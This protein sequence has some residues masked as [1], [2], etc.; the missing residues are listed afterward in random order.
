MTKAILFA[1]AVL[2]SGCAAVSTTGTAALPDGNVSYA[3]VGPASPG[4]PTV[5]FQ[6]GLGDGKVVWSQVLPAVQQHAQVFAYDRPGYGASRMIPGPRD[7]CT[8]AAEERRVLQV[9]GVK[10]PY[11]LVGHS[12]GG[13]YQY[14][15]AKMYPADVAGIV[16][17][18]PTHPRH[19]ETLQRDMPTTASA[20]KTMGSVMF[21]A[22]MRREFD[23]QT[24]CLNTINMAAPLHVPARVLISTETSML[25][26]ASFKESVDGLSADWARMT[27]AARAEPIAKSGHYIQREQPQAVIDA[28]TAVLR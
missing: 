18:D 26:S 12:L 5:V 17:L 13:L 23:D 16:L 7:A 19:W 2:L 25:M 21:Q 9:A 11:L 22:A 1:A 14:V 6:S 27:G 4:N 20:I 24:G 3:L 15:F 10:P 28:I 8:I